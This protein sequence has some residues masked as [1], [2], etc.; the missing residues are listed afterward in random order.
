MQSIGCIL[1][2]IVLICNQ[3][4]AYMN[5]STDRIAREILLKAPQSRVWRA[6]SNAEEFGTW[7][8]VDLK[9]KSF[10]AGKR[11]AGQITHPGYEHIL[12]DVVIERL[13]PERLLSFR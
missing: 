4:V 6:V 2:Q 7:F 5:T 13:E 12:W 1:S 11:V 8:G 10:A 9:G 3:E